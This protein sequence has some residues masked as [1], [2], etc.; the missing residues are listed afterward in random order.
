MPINKRLRS[1]NSGSLYCILHRIVSG[2]RSDQPCSAYHKGMVLNLVLQSIWDALP[3]FR[4]VIRST[5]LASTPSTSNTP[6][7]RN[8][9]DQH[10]P[11]GGLFQF[12]TIY[13]RRISFFHV[14]YIHI[15]IQLQVKSEKW[16]TSG[17]FA[18]G[19]TSKDQCLYHDADFT[20]QKTAVNNEDICK[21]VALL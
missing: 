18:S 7:T 5:S 16:M 17:C 12:K 2:W 4:A 3:G 8:L 13:E 20:T 21:F 1:K 19:L 11:V 10:P 15:S 6:F 9:L 14:T